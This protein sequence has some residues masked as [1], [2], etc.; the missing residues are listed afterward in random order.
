MRRLDKAAEVCAWA[1]KHCT[2]GDSHSLPPC[3]DGYISCDR[4]EARIEWLLGHTNQQRGGFTVLTAEKY[5]PSIGAQIIWDERQ[6]KKGDYILM[7]QVGTTAPNAAWHMFTLASDYGER[8][9]KYDLG[10]NE[11]IQAGGFFR[12]VPFNEWPGRREFYCAFRF[13]EERI[14][15]KGILK[16]WCK[17]SKSTSVRF[18]RKIMRAEGY[19]GAKGRLL[20]ISVN[21]DDNAMAALRSFKAREGINPDIEVC[22]RSA[23]CRLIELPM[24]KDSF[25]LYSWSEGDSNRSVLLAQKCLR[26]HGY[27]IKLDGV[28]GKETIR[29]LLKFKRAVGLNETK[30]CKLR[31]WRKLTGIKIVKV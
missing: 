28:A 26:A 24:D 22:T 11:R 16:D 20:T 30:S 4:L 17:G 9:D 21:A 23:W 18:A 29:A 2:Y 27:D 1:K 12:G 14:R 6:T 13:P 5:L 31:T 3:E 8:I 25:T 7:K 10:S 15:Y 19:K